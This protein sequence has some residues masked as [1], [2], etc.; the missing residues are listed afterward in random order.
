MNMDLNNVERVIG[1]DAHPDSFTAAVLRGRT[2]AEAILEKTYNK[3]PMSQL[4]AWAQK[5]TTAKDLFVLEASGNSFEIVRLLAALE[6]HALVLESCQL[7]KLKEAHANND[8]ISA[9]RIGKAYL[10]GTAKTVWLPDA[11]TQERRDWFHAHRKAV[12]RTTQTRNRVL[13]YLSDNGVRLPPRTALTEA[14]PTEELLRKQRDWTARQWQ[15][16][17]A[18]LLELR[19]ADAQRK[20]W[21]SLIA[22]E[23]T[24]DPE[25][26]SIVRL[27]GVRDL[28]A[29]A[30]GAIVGDI[31]RFADPKKLVKYVGL[32]PAFDESG[33]GQWKGGIGGHGR[34]DLRCLLIEAAQ[35][36]LRSKHELAK[37]GKKLL[38]RKGSLNLA[39]AALARKL[40]VAVWYLMMGRWTPLEEIDGRLHIKIGKII[41]QV[42]AASLKKLGKTRKDLREQIEATLKTGRVYQLDRNKKFEPKSKA[43]APTSPTITLREEYGIV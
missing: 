2:P 21:R 26:L 13:S 5:N 40:T 31:K 4:K 35:S 1:F 18:Y 6:R 16:L 7:G 8:K 11:K 20:H 42:G 24:S 28:V 22:Q 25:L 34:K 9:V 39:V 3:I 30:L 19:H 27:C 33:E 37:W 23:V 32:N 15:V 10:A 17:E 43:K 12:K 38:A 36:I 29:F 14:N 41:S